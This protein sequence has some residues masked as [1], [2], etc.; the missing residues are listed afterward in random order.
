M[1]SELDRLSCIY[2]KPQGVAT[3][4]VIAAFDEAAAAASGVHHPFSYTR[5]PR[6]SA[7]GSATGSNAVLAIDTT[8]SYAGMLVRLVLGHKQFL[9]TR[10]TNTF[11]ADDGR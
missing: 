7:R 6:E 5:R 11:F 9:T 8:P 3:P 1:L 10:V 4:E 2:G